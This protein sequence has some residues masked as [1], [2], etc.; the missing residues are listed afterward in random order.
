MTSKKS[1]GK[2]MFTL[3]VVLLVH[4]TD[5]ACFSKKKKK[6]WLGL[7]KI[8]K[9]KKKTDGALFAFKKIKKI[10][11][12][13]RTGPSDPNSSNAILLRLFFWNN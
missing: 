1:K 12:I 3:I 10:K 4:S 2:N 13:K 5:L 8:N 9:K 7:K 11:R 6:N